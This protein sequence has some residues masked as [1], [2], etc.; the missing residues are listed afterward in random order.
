MLAA[1]MILSSLPASGA[2]ADGE[3][4]EKMNLS[5]QFPKGSDG[6]E[7]ILTDG[8]ADTFVTIVKAKEIKAELPDGASTLVVRWHALPETLTIQFMNGKN[9]LHE[10]KVSADMF[11]SIYTLPEGTSEVVFSAGKKNDEEISDISV[12][13][14]GDLPADVQQWKKAGKTDVL[15][16]APYPGDE[17]RFFGGLIPTLLQ[18][19]VSFNICYMADYS[20]RRVQEGL[21]ALWNLGKTEYP[22]FLSVDSNHSLEYK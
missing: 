21:D 6:K 7:D 4:A 16:I 8:R 18:E 17:Y 13:G 22:V 1:L 9:V 12:Y 20:R 11:Q 10:E 19:G 14:K 3:T 2:E 5:F 15:V